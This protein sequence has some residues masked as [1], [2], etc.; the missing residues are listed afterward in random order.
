MLVGTPHAMA[1]E[2]WDYKPATPASDLYGLGVIGYRI[3]TGVRVFST[4]R[5]EHLV[6]LVRHADPL[7]PSEH[8]SSV[9]KDLE[10]IIL[11]CLAKDPAKRPADARAL[12]EALESCAHAGAWTRA[13][14]VKWWE[15]NGDFLAN[16]VQQRS[17]TAIPVK[18]AE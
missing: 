18:D 3:L 13:D 15:E 7:P 5:L 1:P 8:L 6:D 16:A 2:V 17:E 12:R 11:A 9:P 4:Q 14:A 10:A